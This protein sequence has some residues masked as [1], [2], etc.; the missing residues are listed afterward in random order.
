MNILVRCRGAAFWV[1]ALI[2]GIVN[3]AFWFWLGWTCHH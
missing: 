1:G 3:A 2:G